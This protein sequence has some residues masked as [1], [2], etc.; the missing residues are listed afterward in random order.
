MDHLRKA[1]THFK[2]PK[3]A[4]D[5]VERRLTKPTSKD[6]NDANNQCTAGAKAT[7]NE[8]K[9]KGHIVIPYSQGLYESIKRICSRYG[10]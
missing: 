10:I 4:L 9:T 1:L 8:V 5:R 2:Y 3:W 7:T 6:N